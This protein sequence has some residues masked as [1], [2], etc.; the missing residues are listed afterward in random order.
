MRIFLAKTIALL[1]QNDR[2]F[3]EVKW[4]KNWTFNCFRVFEQIF[5]RE[6]GIR[7]EVSAQVDSEGNSYVAYHTVESALVDFEEWV[8]SK[9]KVRPFKLY[10]PQLATPQGVVFTSPYLF[11]IAYVT[12]GNT[13][14]P[15]ANTSTVTLTASGSDRF[16]VMFMLSTP[17]TAYT[18]MTVDGNASTQ[19]VTAYNPFGAQYLWA[20]VYVAPPSSSVNYVYTRPV[21]AG[22]DMELGV[23][24]YSG[25][26][27]ST[28]IDSS[29]TG[30]GANA[31]PGVVTLS[32]TVV[33]SNCWL[34]SCAR[35]NAG[36]ASASTG[37]TLRQAGTSL[38]TGDSNGTVGT[39]A[40]TMTWTR[41]QLSQTG[42]IIFSLAPSVGTSGPANLKS[43]NTNVA[44][45]I[46]SI[47]TNLIANVKSLNTNV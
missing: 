44:A 22:N 18:S 17:N 13:Y 26:N 32:T 29:N 42:G 24:L 30:V 47:N 38:A 36:A 6:Y 35:N 11:A 39:G 1:T 34:V 46:K 3:P 4:S 40:Q 12:S 2:Y 43:Y 20:N 19:K 15:S 28:T 9:F 31:N 10:I 33:A 25:V 41:A 23:L 16:A 8:R 14:V 5:G 37:T 7:A 27:Q 21:D 45:N